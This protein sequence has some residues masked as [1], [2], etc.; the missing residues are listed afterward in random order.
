MFF[1]RKAN[2][3]PSQVKGWMSAL[4]EHTSEELHER[5]VMESIRLRLF[6]QSQG[7]ANVGSLFSSITKR[8]E[9]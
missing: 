5:N 6:A 2:L 9:N 7:M 1:N 8:P 3:S 4:N